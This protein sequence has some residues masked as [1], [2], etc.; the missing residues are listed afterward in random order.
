V[1]FQLA[2]LDRAAFV[3]AEEDVE[4]GAVRQVLANAERVE[5]LC[6]EAYA[7]LYESDG[8][9]LAILGQVWRRVSDLAAID[10][11]DIMSTRDGIKS[12][13]EDLAPSAAYADKHQASPARLQ[14][15]EERLRCSTV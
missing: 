10:P 12:Q 1:A 5:R 4:L 14:Q 8:A 9:A 15:V 2:E 3:S 13:L 11:L 6:E 7:S